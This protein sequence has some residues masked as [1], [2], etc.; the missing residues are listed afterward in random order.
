MSKVV[1]DWSLDVVIVSINLVKSHLRND[2]KISTPEELWLTNRKCFK[3]EFMS[4]LKSC[5]DKV[6]WVWFENCQQEQ[7]FRKSQLGYMLLHIPVLS[8]LI[9]SSVGIRL[10]SCIILSTS[11]PSLVYYYSA[12][13]DHPDQVQCTTSSSSHKGHGSCLHQSSLVNLS[14]QWHS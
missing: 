7:V 4:I 10:M 12:W 5:K 3:V 6:R 9:S 11:L 14:I 1:K 13:L 2:P 8:C